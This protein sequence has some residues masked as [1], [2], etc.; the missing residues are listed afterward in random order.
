MKKYRTYGFGTL[1]QTFDERQTTRN[2]QEAEFIDEIHEEAEYDR[3]KRSFAEEMRRV[4][5]HDLSI[6]KKTEK[7][8]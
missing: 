2:K 4:R 5:I 6:K 7:R 3:W 1:Y 8:D